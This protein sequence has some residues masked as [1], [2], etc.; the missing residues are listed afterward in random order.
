MIETLKLDPDTR[1]DEEIKI[2]RARVEGIH[3]A[4]KE[5]ISSIDKIQEKYATHG[6]MISKEFSD[7]KNELGVRVYKDWKLE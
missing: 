6:Y 3:F 5:V 1:T 4:I 7:L 2:S